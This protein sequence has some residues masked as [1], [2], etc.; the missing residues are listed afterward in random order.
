M[1][2]AHN[3]LPNTSTGRTP[4]EVSLGYHPP[5]LPSQEPVVPL[6]H[7]FIQHCQ[8]TWQ[9]TRSALER[10]QVSTQRTA[11][12]HRNSAPSYQ[13]GQLV[14]LN[15]KNIPLL[16]ESR[17]LSPRFNGPFPVKKVINP[18]AFR[19]KLPSNMKI[20]P[21]FHVSQLKPVSSSPLCPPS[22]TPPP[23]RIID[24]HPAFIV[25]CLVDSRRRRRGLQYLVNWEGYGPEELSW[26][27]RSFILD[28]DLI[29]DFHK[30]HPD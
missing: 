30:A 15:T 8:R 22:E 29:S 3:N 6:V 20:H 23:A 14:W 11:N 5:L 1:E 19:L 10:A 13:F 17:K 26:V 21:T 4:F 25:H 2:Y 24:D 28:P 16:S 9:E 27:P 12:K 7:D 18:S